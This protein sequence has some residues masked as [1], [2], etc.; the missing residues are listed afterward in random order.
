MAGGQEFE[1][2]SKPWDRNGHHDHDGPAQS[3]KLLSI[4]APFA[5]GFAG[6]GRWSESLD[7]LE[8]ELKRVSRSGYLSEG[9]RCHRLK[10]GT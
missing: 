3:R 10:S 4:E 2:L 6:E 5:P 8:Q 7:V 1:A 9:H